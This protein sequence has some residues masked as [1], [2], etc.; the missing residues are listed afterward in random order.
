MRIFK[1]K[2]FTRFARREQLGDEALLEAIERAESGLVDADLGGHLIKQRVARPGGGRSGGY[3]TIIVYRSGQ[4]AIFVYGFAKNDRN[5]L[6]PDEEVGFK[7]SATDY[8]AL[9][10]D[11][12]DSMAATGTLMEIDHH[13]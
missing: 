12:L 7:K 13:E 10:D 9:T 11:Q 5:N 1:T 4:R 8:L 2:W 6:L 3:R